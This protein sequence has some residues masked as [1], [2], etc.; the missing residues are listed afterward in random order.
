MAAPVLPVDKW[1]DVL[2]SVLPVVWSKH[3]LNPKQINSKTTYRLVKEVTLKK[4]G[5]TEAVVE[6]FLRTHH[7]T[8]VDERPPPM[9]LQPSASSP[10]LASG[11]AAGLASKDSKRPAAGHKRGKSI[12]EGKLREL[13]HSPMA[14]LFDEHELKARSVGPSMKFWESHAHP[15][16]HAAHPV[17][18]SSSAVRRKEFA[19]SEGVLPSQG[20]AWSG[21][22]THNLPSSAVP[23]G[24]GLSL[25]ELLSPSSSPALTVPPSSHGSMVAPS[26]ARSEAAV[27]GLAASNI[28]E[29]MPPLTPRGAATFAQSTASAAS[30]PPGGGLAG[31]GLGS[32]AVRSPGGLE[33]LE[34]LDASPMFRQRLKTVENEL[35][36]FGTNLK[37]MVQVCKD[38]CISGDLYGRDMRRFAEGLEMFHGTFD[39]DIA[40]EAVLG[41]LPYA[42]QPPSLPYAAQP[43]IPCLHSLWSCLCCGLVPW[44][45]VPGLLWLSGV[46]GWYRRACCGQGCHVLLAASRPCSAVVRQVEQLLL[47]RSRACLCACAGLCRPLRLRRWLR[48]AAAADRQRC[49]CV[50]VGVGADSGLSLCGNKMRAVAELRELLLVAMENAVVQPMELFADSLKHARHLARK[51]DK[52]IG[53]YDAL[54]SRLTN[55]SKHSKKAEQLVEGA[56]GS[57]QQC[58]ALLVDALNDADSARRFGLQAALLDWLRSMAL[59]FHNGNRLLTD[60]EPLIDELHQALA[61][62]QSI[63]DSERAEMHK[64]R[65]TMFDASSTSSPAAPEPKLTAKQGYLFKLKGQH[66]HY[67]RGTVWKKRFFIVSDGMMLEKKQLNTVDCM[68]LV[69]ASVKTRPDLQDGKFCFE[70]FT[71]AKTIVLQAESQDQLDDWISVIQH[72]IAQELNAQPPVSGPR[73]MSALLAVPGCDDVYVDG[74]ALAALEQMAAADASGPS[75][76]FCADCGAAEHEWASINHGV[77]LCIECS[78]IHRA[79]GVHISKVRS[80]QLDKWQPETLQMMACLGSARLNAILE[81]E[82]PPPPSPDQPPGASSLPAPSPPSLSSSNPS[83]TSLSASPGHAE[84]LVKPT[85]K[86]S[87]EHRERWIRAKYDHKRFMRPLETTVPPLQQLLAAVRCGDCVHLLRLLLH[88]V[89]LNAPLPTAA[90]VDRQTALHVAISLRQMSCAQLLVLNRA[91]VDLLD[92]HRRTPLHYA[93]ANGDMASLVLILRNAEQ[94][95]A[96]VDAADADGLTPVDL[97]IQSGTEECIQLLTNFRE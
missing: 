97:A 42:S 21:D 30:G 51:Y 71:P 88:S 24:H 23:A 63:F 39:P 62:K 95:E 5:L 47:A 82:T 8:S 79:L 78:G 60:V 83:S 4:M 14:A 56:R 17:A 90:P 75:S 49:A 87:R 96:M 93:A 66:V 12:D 15:K 3:S 11:A 31:G 52:R 45:L 48:S 55:N 33:L 64:R 70:I 68:P 81:P 61:K 36:Q 94:P 59:Y 28:S 85:V 2:K 32:S 22:E 25:H 10:M 40:D 37:E 86:A 77:T 69:T 29:L 76:L 84:P 92:A 46:V 43:P 57:M 58:G 65:M 67:V 89:D 6:E 16:P 80:L 91:Q 20:L 7:N 54:R 53:E 26:S 27:G 35:V 41:S 72:T 13:G 18:A 34:V 9:Q 74:S 38:C 19:S 73:R 44:L 50:W 1:D